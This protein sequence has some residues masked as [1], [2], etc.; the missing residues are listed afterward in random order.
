ME[1][2]FAV[3]SDVLICLSVR[4]CWEILHAI[5]ISKSVE[6]ANQWKCMHFT[7]ALSLDFLTFSPAPTLFLSRSRVLSLCRV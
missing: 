4:V 6:S 5:L 3:G 7:C 2:K 1:Q